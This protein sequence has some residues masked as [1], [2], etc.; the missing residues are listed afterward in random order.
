MTD[1][2]LSSRRC[3]P[4]SL[5]LIARDAPHTVRPLCARMRE[6]SQW[7]GGGPGQSLSSRVGGIAD[8]RRKFASGISGGGL[9]TAGISG[10][11]LSVAGIRGGGFSAQGISGGR[12]VRLRHQGRRL[13][14]CG[15]RRGWAIPPQRSAVADSQRRVSVV[16]A[17]PRA[18]SAAAACVLRESAVVG[19]PP[20]G[21][22]VVDSQCTV[23]EPGGTP[24]AM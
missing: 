2:L 19:N 23:C 4:N 3:V 17:S 7:P 16:V 9:F 24:T 10:S 13:V 12:K 1:E 11:G 6:A 14:C 20:Q 5:Q 22:T 15:N 18:V 8:R 21:S